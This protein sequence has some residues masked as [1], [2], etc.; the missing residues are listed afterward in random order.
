[1]KLLDLPINVKEL[2]ASRKENEDPILARSFGWS[3]TPEKHFFWSDISKVNQE[4][5][6]GD[7]VKF[8][9]Y[10]SEVKYSVNQDSNGN[11]YLQVKTSYKGSNRFIFK[12]LSLDTDVVAKKVYGY[13]ISGDFPLAKSLRE[14]NKMIAY[15]Q[16]ECAY[17][18]HSVSRVASVQSS[19]TPTTP[20]APP[21]SSKAPI[22]V[23]QA[24][25]F[26]GMK[27]IRGRDW[28]WGSQDSETEFGVITK[29][30]NTSKNYN[31]YTVEWALK[32]SNA[33]KVGLT[34]KDTC[35]LYQYQPIVPVDTI[36]SFVAKEFG[37]PFATV[38]G[39][40]DIEK[41]L[42]QEYTKSPK[43]YKV[44]SLGDI[45]FIHKHTKSPQIIELLPRKKKRFHLESSSMKEFI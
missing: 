7:V 30:G 27:V 13:T 35:D 9:T 15:L 25:A 43:A 14:L 23:T 39:L 33:Y 18:K 8:T 2:A 19:S 29:L 16:V 6:R 12:I 32:Q 44:E 42:I 40:G 11:W 24:N 22:I 3:G 5:T 37:S 38:E 20:V 21:G 41:F 28:N 36:E 45:E 34:E 1:M 4:Y 17:S 10:N 31:W 26:V